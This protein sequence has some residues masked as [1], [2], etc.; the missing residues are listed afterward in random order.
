MI[1]FRDCMRKIEP[2]NGK[3]DKRINKIWGIPDI[4]VKFEEELAEHPEWASLLIKHKPQYAVIE[5]NMNKS[6]RLFSLTIFK[7]GDDDVP[8][9]ALILVH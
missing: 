6:F 3:A 2:F 5:A 4:E 9:I 1:T 7:N 8:V